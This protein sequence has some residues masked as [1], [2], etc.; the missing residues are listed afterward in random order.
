MKKQIYFA[1]VAA[2]F[3]FGIS[4]SARAQDEV[5]MR[6]MASYGGISAHELAEA[7]GYFKG[8]GVMLPTY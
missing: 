6:Y 1:W 8:T 7:L 2:L 4:A 5:T 3:L